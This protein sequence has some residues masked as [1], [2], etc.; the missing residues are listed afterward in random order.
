[1]LLEAGIALFV[2]SMTQLLMLG[3][4]IGAAEQPAV[5]IVAAT[6]LLLAGLWTGYVGGV[7]TGAVR[8]PTR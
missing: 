8:G 4:A 1:M 7:L 5:R 6:E 3:L 2:M